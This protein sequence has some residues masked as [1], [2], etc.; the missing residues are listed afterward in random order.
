MVDEL[1]EI[2]YVDQ[3]VGCPKYGNVYRNFFISKE[4]KKFGYVVKIFSGSFSHLMYK[5][6]TTTGSITKESIEDI[7]FNWVKVR[8]YKSGKSYGRVLAI[9][10]FSLRIL[11]LWKYPPPD[12]IITPSVPLLPF[13]TLYFLKVFKW[14]NN[15]VKIILEIRDIWPLSLIKLGGF[16]RSNP[17]ITLLSITERIAYRKSDYIISTL[18]HCDEHIQSVYNRKFNFEWIDNG[19]YLKDGSEG[20]NLSIDMLLADVPKGKFIIG[21]T[22][23]LGVANAMKY[24]IES[25]IILKDDER[26][27]F[28]IVGDGYEK[29]NLQQMAL[30][31]ENITFI[32][33]INKTLVPLILKQFD[34]LYFSYANIPELYK[35]G[36]SANKTYE[37]M[38]SGIP[39]LLSSVEI[40]DNII[41]I[42]RCGKVV[43]PESSVEIVNGIVWMFELSD[44]I[45]EKM[46]SNGIKYITENNTFEVLAN[47]L[48][49]VFHQV[50]VQ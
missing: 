4:L 34:L 8:K 17:F 38:S 45:R 10:D 28:V 29:E 9:F 41:Q 39:I 20:G 11:K 16:K 40:R 49:K 48:V 42:A 50:L 43:P 27:H 19:I 37:Y 21:Y 2:W 36:V 18:R 7:E 3:Y 35:F 47:K 12:I 31:L 23:A 5:I 6:P 44:S 46:G 25:A 13:L 26:F 15:K 1:N 22:G 33:K 32:S 24:F 30:G 14:R